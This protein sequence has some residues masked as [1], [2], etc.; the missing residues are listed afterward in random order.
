VRDNPIGAVGFED[1]KR[2]GA[3]S[4]KTGWERIV[5]ADSGETL[6]PDNATLNIYAASAGK[7]FYMRPRGWW[8]GF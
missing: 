7:V 3:T 4:M 1:T 8:R 6:V 2:F 5:I